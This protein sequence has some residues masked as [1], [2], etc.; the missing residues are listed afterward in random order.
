MVQRSLSCPVI[1]HRSPAPLS[2]EGDRVRRRGGGDPRPLRLLAGEGLRPLLLRR[3]GGE[4]LLLRARYR[5]TSRSSLL[6]RT[7]QLSLNLSS[8]RCPSRSIT[9]NPD[10]ASG[11]VQGTHT[12][13]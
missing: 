3:R 9:C 12:G 7:S 5:S 13:A 1:S 2:L 8:S 10:A 4:R 6:S 11:L